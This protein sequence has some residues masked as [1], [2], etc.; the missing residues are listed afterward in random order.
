MSKRINRKCL[1]LLALFVYTH[2]SVG[3]Q[4][5]GIEMHELAA[6]IKKH[7]SA[8]NVW[9]NGQLNMVIPQAVGQNVG[10]F[11]AGGDDQTRS[12]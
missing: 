10:K 4:A 6:A 11:Y 8:T 1:F 12:V 5:I 7:T 9:I 2:F 3:A